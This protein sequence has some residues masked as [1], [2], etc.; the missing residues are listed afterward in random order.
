MKFVLIIAFLVAIP[1]SVYAQCTQKISDLPAAAELFGFHLG[2]T[3]EQ[4][5]TLVPQIHLDRKNVV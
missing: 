2:M 1:F 3:K 4:V 5:K